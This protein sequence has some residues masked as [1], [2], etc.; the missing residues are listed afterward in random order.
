MNPQPRTFRATV[1]A[2]IGH[3]ILPVV[4]FTL[5]T[6]TA[7][8][9][10][11]LN[12][13]VGGLAL[14]L[15]LVVLVVR[16]LLPMLR[17]KLHLDR[18]SIKGIIAGRTFEVYWSDIIAAWVVR[19]KRTELLC[20]GTRD[21]TLIIPMRFFDGPRLW[22]YVRGVVS[23]A[24]LQETAIQRLPDYREWAAARK[25]A[26]EEAAQPGNG[27]RPITDHW[28]MQVIGW[29]GLT[30]FMFGAY[31]SYARSEIAATLVLLVLAGVSL[32]MLLSWGITE[33]SPAGVER[34]TLFGCW[35]ITWE[36]VRRVEID[37]ADLVM[38]L[39]G[40]DRTLALPGP[41]MW[42][43][44]GKSEALAMLLAQA[45]KHGIPLQRTPFALFKIS[46]NTR[47]KK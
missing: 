19:Q 36:Q 47:L 43:A 27:P 20:L 11:D 16:V 9:T 3:L 29:A 4:F 23:P 34:S 41:A 13:L 17:D 37:P 5:L 25:S 31:D 33:F 24:A 26:L 40:E 38:V 12:P 22:E 32:V 39:V 15:V 7:A 45:E 42:N 44:A 8:E 46:R 35:R 1:E 2:W 30:F 18:R 6:F 28:I 10:T 14:S 21:G